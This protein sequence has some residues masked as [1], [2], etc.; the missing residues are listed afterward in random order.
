MNGELNPQPTQETDTEFFAALLSH[1][2][3]MDSNMWSRVQ[4]LSLVQAAAF[5]G[6]YTIRSHS[7]I[8]VGVFFIA[9]VFTFAVL[10]MMK[11]DEK[12]RD[13]NRKLIELLGERLSAPYEKAA[14]KFTMDPHPTPE[15]PFK[16]R[17]LNRFIF[18]A[19][20]VLDMVALIYFFCRLVCAL[21]AL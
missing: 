10:L 2:H 4:Y 7:L 11:R 12:I 15:V 5:G 21:A 19:F 6:A 18:A 17:Q 8:V 16:G 3:H 1:F 9:I 20:I 13:C 14:G